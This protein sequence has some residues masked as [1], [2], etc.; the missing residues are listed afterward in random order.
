M[1]R[2]FWYEGVAFLGSLAR[3]RGFAADGIACIGHLNRRCSPYR[4][5]AIGFRI[6]AMAEAHK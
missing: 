2:G 3:H 4:R 5:E 6:R 1:P